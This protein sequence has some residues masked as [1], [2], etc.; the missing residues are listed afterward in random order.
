MF[1]EGAEVDEAYEDWAAMR[2][3]RGSVSEDAEASIDQLLHRRQLTKAHMQA[4][5][6]MDT[7]GSSGAN[8]PTIWT[9]QF[10]AAQL[11]PY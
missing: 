3:A 1:D 10:P 7:F 6:A 2:H 5:Q 8:T 11:R 4:M 9:A